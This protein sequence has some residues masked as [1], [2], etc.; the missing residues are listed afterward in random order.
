M[1]R[2]HSRRAREAEPVRI[3]T[4]ASNRADDI[5]ARQ[6][7]YLIS[8]SIRSACFIGA[9]VAA[10]AGIGWLWPILIFG[11]LLLPYVAVVMAN[12]SATR[13]DGFELREGDF[14]R[15][16]LSAGPTSGAPDA[17]P[18]DHRSATDRI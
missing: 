3:T 2:T 17:A 5:A 10:L 12:N 11:A 15:G 9:I 7:R 4:A 1:A 13:S 8:M 6:K 14:G 16:Q 18:T